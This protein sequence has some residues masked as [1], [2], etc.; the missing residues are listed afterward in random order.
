MMSIVVKPQLVWAC[1]GDIADN[2]DFQTCDHLVSV[3]AL[4][5][6]EIA[7][8]K[9]RY[10]MLKR[11]REA[12]TI[13]PADVERMKQERSMLMEQ[14]AQLNTNKAV[15]QKAIHELE[16]GYQKLQADIKTRIQ[17]Y[18]EVWREGTG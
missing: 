17:Q 8:A 7:K 2:T 4:A 18:N 14:L 1:C 11:K 5:D 16:L 10:E 15:T 6:Q 12:Q 13:S 9:A 3:F